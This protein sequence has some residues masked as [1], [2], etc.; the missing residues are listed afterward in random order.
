MVVVSHAMVSFLTSAWMNDV[1]KSV[2]KVVQ[3]PNSAGV[4]ARA[5]SARVEAHVVAEPSF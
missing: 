2:K 3:L 5:C 1:L 4:F